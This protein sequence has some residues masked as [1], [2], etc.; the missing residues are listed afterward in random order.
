[1]TNDNDLIWEAILEYIFERTTEAAFKFWITPLTF[2][3]IEDGVAYIAS[4]KEICNNVVKQAY[5]EMLKDAF[6]SVTGI[7]VEIAYCEKW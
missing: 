3:G 4:D 7:Q 1:M 5:D 6:L 2:Y